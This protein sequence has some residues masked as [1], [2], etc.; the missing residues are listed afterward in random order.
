[1]VHPGLF[2][3]SQEA[4]L[5]DGKG[6]YDFMKVTSPDMRTFEDPPG[7]LP[8]PMYTSVRMWH[9]F[10]KVA[11]SLGINITINC[12]DYP[13]SVPVDSKL[14]KEDVMNLFRS[15]YEGTPFDMRL[16][17]LAGPWSSPNRAEAGWGMVEVPGQIG[18]GISIHRTAYTQVGQTGIKHPKVWFGPD[19]AAS[20]VFVPFYASA[21]AGG[22]GKYDDKSFGEGSMKEL[23]FFAPVKP[24][25]WAFDFVANWLDHS[26][27]NMS[28]Q[29]VTPKV[30]A[31][32]GNVSRACAAAE[33][34]AE[35]ASS[36]KHSELALAEEQTRI[37]R[38]VSEEWWKFAGLLVVRYNDLNYNFP[39]E[40]PDMQFGIGYP[41]WWLE[42]VGFND[43]SF[44]PQWV[45]PS[46]S[47]PK[48]MP[49]DAKE[50]ALGIQTDPHIAGLLTGALTE[51][52]ALPAAPTSALG[53]VS[54]VVCSF[55]TLAGGVVMGYHLGAKSAARDMERNGYVQITA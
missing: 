53:W 52:A 25:W 55:S 1:M 6:E 26:Y 16:G 34:K 43:N 31:L 44:L 33:A 17:V 38:H 22:E 32:Q 23:D 8:I 37:Q 54:L 29:F 10:S 5:W 15:H 12:Y 40:F 50:I 46:N 24:A 42:M 7:T 30:Q 36:R 13:F 9:V 41:A 21:L 51:A 4:G 27:L 2:E 20:S 35:E 47:V 3:L 11:P 18:R 19:A 45:A 14:G 48:L 39:D 28:G 49:S